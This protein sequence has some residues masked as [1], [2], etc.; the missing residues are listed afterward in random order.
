MSFPWHRFMSLV[1]IHLFST[2]INLMQEN[3]C[4]CF[5]SSLEKPFFVNENGKYLVINRIFEIGELKR[6]I[7]FCWKGVDI[8]C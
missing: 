6:Y 8:G 1:M 3:T 5:W 4:V 2:K 7:I